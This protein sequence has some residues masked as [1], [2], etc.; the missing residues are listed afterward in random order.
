M[1]TLARS[2]IALAWLAAAQHA[3]AQHWSFENYGAD[4][5]LAN[6]V[7]FGLHQDRE[8]FI[9]AATEDGL[10]RYDGDR[11]QPYSLKPADK[12]GY[13]AA[14]YT[15]ADAQ[16][17]AGTGAGLFRWNGSDFVRVPGFETT[18]LYSAEAISGDGANLYLAT[19]AG[20]RSMPLH[21]GSIQELY[22]GRSYSVFAAKEGTVW[23]SCGTGVCTWQ[24][25]GVAEYLVDRGVPS[26]LWRSIAEDTAGRIWLRS[27]DDVVVREP[28]AARFQPIAGLP[29]LASTYAPGLVAT[30]RGEILIPHSTGIEICMAMAC[31]N[32]DASNGL[33]RTEVLGV[34]EDREGSIW[35]G[36][37]GRGIGRWQGRELW[38][39]F[40]ELKGLED[41]QI[42]RVTRDAS[43]TLW[44][45]TNRGLYSGAQ[46]DGRWQFTKAKAVPETPIYALTPDQDGSLWIGTA[47]TDC[48]LIRYHPHTEQVEQYIPSQPGEN[49]TVSGIA[50]A[51]GGTVWVGSRTGL[52][53]VGAGRHLVRA[54]SPLNDAA[55]FDV[56]ANKNGLC[57]AT[58][59]GLYVQQGEVRRLLTSADGLKNDAVMSVV[60]GPEGELWTAYFNPLGL[61]RVDIKGSRISTRTVGV[62]D[63]LPSDMIFS[64]FFD[65]AGR[66]WAGSDKGISVWQGGRWNTYGMSDG[67]IWNDCN[68]HSY[69]TEPDGSFWVGTSSGI[70]RYTPA[71][72]PQPGL[73]E[74]RV[75]SVMRNDV[76]ASGVNFD[77]NT[78][79]LAL[80][81]TML[82]YRRPALRFRYRLGGPST[83]WSETRNHE[84]R[85][86]QPPSGNHTFEVQGEAEPGVWT[87]PAQ[88]QFHIRPPWYFT[89]YVDSCALMMMAASVWWWWSARERRERR[90]REA[91]ETAVCERTRDLAAATNRA[92]QA[93]RAKSEFLANMSHEIRTP[94]NG[95]VAM[96]GF[97]LDT[98]LNPNQRE[99]AEIVRRS[100]ENLLGLVND[101]L[102]YSKLEA[103]RLELARRPFDLV[104]VIE[105]VTSLLAS[106]A[107]QKCIDLVLDYPA[108]APRRFIGAMTRVR[109]VLLNLAGNAIK[110]SDGGSVLISV[111]PLSA[112]SAGTEMRIA[113]TDTGI[114]IAEEKLPL[115]FEKFSQ[116]DGSD[117]RKHGGAGL[118]LAICDRLVRL[119]GGSIGV[120]SRQ[121]EGSTFWFRLPLPADET[122]APAP[123]PDASLER[124]RALIVAPKSVN[125]R[126]LQQSLDEFG[127]R[128]SCAAGMDEAIL[129]LRAAAEAGDPF[130]IVLRDG[131]PG[132]SRPP[133]FR[134]CAVVTL[135]LGGTSGETAAG[136][137]GSHDVVVR[138]PARR[139]ELAQAIRS[140]LVGVPVPQPVRHV[141]PVRVGAAPSMAADPPQLNSEVCIL[142]VEDNPVNQKVASRLF[143]RMGLRTEVAANG[144]EAVDMFAHTPYD[145]ILMDCQM[146][147]MDGYEASRLIRQ[148]PGAGA[149]VPI[150]ACTADA[151]E[152]ARDR[153]IDAGMNDCLTKPVNPAKLE[154]VIGRWLP[155]LALA[156]R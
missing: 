94:M 107:E 30:R 68:A 120:E 147:V 87:L 44:V 137:R 143:E 119:M 99:C 45:G 89:W 57:A 156:A 81:F 103:G 102:D 105:D 85:F 130:R 56:L 37:R 41:S 33:Q 8:G 48:G 5:G 27:A 11:F 125:Q 67:F 118:G 1:V 10:F 18:G 62:R 49:L 139:S 16:L 47:K 77:A 141:E 28:G 29:H 39:S 83:P 96:A 6:P 108:A 58:M 116:V 32:Y 15:S 79:S 66:Q 4:Q 7:V 60:M 90:V 13:G 133:E 21:G 26:G 3:L 91:L 100:S 132:L 31:R 146:P 50:V 117:T 65:A 59:K 121:G 145:F 38:Q 52:F 112:S 73:P 149:T 98:E 82:A 124:L 138:K 153:C 75:I 136:G 54:P 152:G 12:R 95:V 134:N 40:S 128:G 23:F 122:A 104:D 148:Q 76:P 113:V 111:A 142:V 92:E 46:K 88:L 123:R 43:G 72:I 36:Y 34:L 80:R 140:A 63:G 64:T 35:V 155:Q 69:L 20:L 126:A 150:V 93:N 61:T 78:D 106:A 131:A 97:L 151:M 70:A 22:Q 127:V 109:Q 154:A 9:W 144:R 84:V 25:G 14:F 115:L 42:W 53:S 51:P 135:T 2:V 71:P 24:D 101:I 55:V 129:L 110:F 86:A 114:G 74:V 17:W 19:R